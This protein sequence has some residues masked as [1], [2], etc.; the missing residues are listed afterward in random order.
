MASS[1]AVSYFIIF[2]IEVLAD[3]ELEAEVHK[4][5]ATGE[6]LTLN[7]MQRHRHPREFDNGEELRDALFTRCPINVNDEWLERTKR[8]ACEWLPEERI[9]NLR[10]PIEWS[11]QGSHHF[12]EQV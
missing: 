6:Q 4:N 3:E 12:A 5:N 9:I 7:L 11:V 8:K 10:Q 1:K 2:R